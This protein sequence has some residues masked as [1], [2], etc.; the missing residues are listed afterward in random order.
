MYT[1]PYT[2]VW[3]ES[4]RQGVTTPMTMILHRVKEF[5]DVTVVINLDS[6]LIKTEIIHMGQIK[7]QSPSI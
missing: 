1:I 2:R 6:E 5:L 4:G 3:V 7:L